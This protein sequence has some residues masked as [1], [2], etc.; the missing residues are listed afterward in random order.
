MHYWT[1]N[2]A[3]EMKRLVALGADGIVTDHADVAIAT[4]R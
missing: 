4:L 1:I 2:D 3:K